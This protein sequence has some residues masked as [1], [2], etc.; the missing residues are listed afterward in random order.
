MQKIVLE[1][2]PSVLTTWQQLPHCVRWHVGAFPLAMAEGEAAEIGARLAT[3][4]PHLVR[5]VTAVVVDGSITVHLACEAVHEGMWG[6]IIC[7]TRR[8]VTFEEQHEILAIDGRVVSDRIALDLPSIVL[9]L[10]AEDG[11]DP[12]ETARMG[13]AHRESRRRTKAMAH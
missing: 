8:R 5:R 10:C 6:N 9:Q 12:D 3:A 11:V 4:F 7:P 2:L 1:V 13:R